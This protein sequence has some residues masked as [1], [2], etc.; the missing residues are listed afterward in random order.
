MSRDVGNS[1]WAVPCQCATLRYPVLRAG[2]R[3]NEAVKPSWVHIGREA[4]QDSLEYDPGR[5]DGLYHFIRRRSTRLAGIAELPSVFAERH[6]LVHHFAQRPIDGETLLPDF[7]EV[8]RSAACWQWKTASPGSGGETALSASAAR[9]LFRAL[10]NHA[11][12]SAT[13]SGSGA[14]KE[15]PLP[16]YRRGKRRGH[17]GPALKAGLWPHH[18]VDCSPGPPQSPV[19]QPAPQPFR[20]RIVRHDHQKVG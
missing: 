11:R 17:S 2:V 9:I 10:T 18:H 20:W 14:V 7:F 5:R 13:S 4:V 19:R 16:H 8:V 12:V 15:H 6:C 1:C 3:P